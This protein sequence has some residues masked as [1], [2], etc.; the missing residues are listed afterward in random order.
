MFSPYLFTG[1]KN[2]LAA[3]L[4]I[5]WILM[6]KDWRILVKLSK[7]KWLLLLLVGLLGGFIPFILFFKGLSMT[8]AAQAG[9]I[10]KLM[11]IFIF[12]FAALWLKEKVKQSYIIGGWLLLLANLF[13]LNFLPVEFNLGSWLILIAVIFWSLESV[14]SKHLLKDLPSR[15][16]IWARMFFGSIFIFVFLAAIGQAGLVF[17]LSWQQAGWVMITGVI[18]F[19]YL[20]TWY[21]GLAYLKVSTASL[22][23]LLASPITSLLS[24]IFLSRN[25]A[26]GEL[27]GFSFVFASILIIL[28][29][30]RYGE[31][32]KPVKLLE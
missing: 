11:F 12:I 6:A 8:S 31:S 16:V 25:L 21:T 2:S 1:L 30:N 7:K 19:G 29:W 15:I 23:L 3:L 20:A 13:L 17:E 27:I 4:A 22:I 32:K 5:S 18:L 24:L 28:F 10:H 9:F 14:I 26:P